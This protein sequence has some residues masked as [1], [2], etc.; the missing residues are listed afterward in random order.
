VWEEKGTDEL[1]AFFDGVADHLTLSL[2]TSKVEPSDADKSGGGDDDVS[3]VTMTALRVRDSQ[4]VTFDSVWRSAALPWCAATR[5]SLTRL[6]LCSVSMGL[7]AFAQLRAFANLSRLDVVSVELLVTGEPGDDHHSAAVS[8]T[9]NALGRLR[10]LAFKRNCVLYPAAAAE[11]DLKPWRS[12]T[13]RPREATAADHRRRVRLHLRHASLRRL[14]V[15]WEPGW[16]V[17]LPPLLVAADC[18][19]LERFVGEQAWVREHLADLPTWWPR[20]ERLTVIRPEER[21]DQTQSTAMTAPEAL[22]DLAELEPALRRWPRLR[23]LELER[24]S[25]EVVS[26]RDHDVPTQQLPPGWTTAFERLTRLSLTKS[27]VGSEQ[28]AELVRACTRLHELEVVA[29]PNV[30]T[31]SALASTSLAT[32]RLGLEIL[33]SATLQL[34]GEPP[35]ISKLGSLF[36]D[37]CAVVAM[38]CVRA[39]VCVCRISEP[40]GVVRGHVREPGGRPPC[41]RHG[42]ALRA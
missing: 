11:L 42:L 41:Q 9:I 25:G 19:R 3:H 27:A 14:E 16:S 10:R 8:D 4:R 2:K 30:T 6:K 7:E 1:R 5:E 38:R 21:P 24:G 33:D 26:I 35:P 15:S 12:P 18:P 28:L 37:M 17:D 34:E 39:W 40:G 23:E 22:L 36:A 29:C 13:G 20:L 31:V 32:L